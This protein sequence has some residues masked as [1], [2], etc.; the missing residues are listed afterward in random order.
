ML[1]SGSEDQCGFAFGCHR[2]VAIRLLCSLGPFG[3][4]F[5]MIPRMCSASGVPT[6]RLSGFH[7]SVPLLAKELGKPSQL[8]GFSAPFDPF[9][10]NKHASSA[11]F[12][13]YGLG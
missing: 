1:R 5:N 8:G 4:R 6:P 2:S 7:H 11:V 3:V 10:G 13:W 9:E 12:C